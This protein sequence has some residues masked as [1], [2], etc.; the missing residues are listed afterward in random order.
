MQY[1]ILILDAIRLV[2]FLVDKRWLKHHLAA[3]DNAL[4]GIRRQSAA[5]EGSV[6]P[7]IDAEICV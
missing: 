6:A 7:C 3:V 2:L 4:S 1:Y 5:G